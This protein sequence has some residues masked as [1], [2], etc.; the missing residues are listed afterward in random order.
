[1]DSAIIASLITGVL[2]LAGV[3]ITNANSNKKIE[4]RLEVSQAITD[5]KLENLANEVR[6]HNDFATKVPVIEQRVTGCENEIKSIK[7]GYHGLENKIVQS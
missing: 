6:R 2:A 5:T 4:H 3:M 1:M 7:E